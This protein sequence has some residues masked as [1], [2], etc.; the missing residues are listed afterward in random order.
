[1]N[2]L[3]LRET[4]A[5]PSTHYRRLTHFFF[6]LKTPHVHGKFQCWRPPIWNFSLKTKRKEEKKGGMNRW[7]GPDDRYFNHARAVE[8]VR[9]HKIFPS[10]NKKSSLYNVFI[11]FFPPSHNFIL[12]LQKETNPVAPLEYY[13]FSEWA[14]PARKWFF[15]C[16]SFLFFLRYIDIWRRY[17]NSI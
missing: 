3:F 2:Q 13:I 1:M 5:S 6:L 10:W 4:K 14:V 15:C 7:R 11:F 12:F 17:H 9:D 16:L 8:C